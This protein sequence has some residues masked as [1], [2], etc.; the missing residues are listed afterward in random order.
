VYLV[1]LIGG[2]AVPVFLA[3]TRFRGVVILAF[4]ALAMLILGVQLLMGLPLPNA[5]ADF[6]SEVKKVDDIGKNAVGPQIN[7]GGNMEMKA[8]Y[9]PSFFGSVLFLLMS[10]T[11]GL[12]QLIVG[13]PKGMTTSRRRAR[14]DLE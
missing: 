5:A 7:I 3:A 11:L 10:A 8:S 2:A 14:D 9:L 4:A 13:G 12:V 1:F 6:N